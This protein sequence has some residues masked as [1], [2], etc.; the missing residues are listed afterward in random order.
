MITHSLRKIVLAVFVFAAIPLSAQIYRADQILAKH[1]KAMGGESLL[2]KLKS[3]K[4]E[5]SVEA[6]GLKGSSTLYAHTPDMTRKEIKL[7]VLNQ[8]SCFNG[9]DQWDI[10]ANGALSIGGEEARKSAYTEALIDC[11]GY[12]FPDSTIKIRYLSREG[13][14][15]RSFV[16]IEVLPEMG[17]PVKLW[18]DE[19][20][21]LIAKS[22]MTSGG[23][24]TTREYDDYEPAEGIMIPR[25]IR[26]S[27]PE[28]E[29]EYN[30]F[31]YTV[32]VNGYMDE[33]LFV[34]TEPAPVDYVIRGGDQSAPIPFEFSNAHI[35]LKGKINGDGPYDF[36]L[37]SGAEVSLVDATTARSLWLAPAGELKAEG[38]G[39]Y[40]GMPLVKVDSI[41]LPGVE[42]YGQVDVSMKPAELS[43]KYPGRPV[44]MVLGYD[45]LSRFAT[46]IRFSDST[47]T[48]HDHEKFAAPA[49]YSFATCSF[50]SHVPLVSAYA[51]GFPGRFILNTGSVTSIDL[52][53]PFIK[54]NNLAKGRRLVPS[55]LHG[56]SG[57]VKMFAARMK[58]FSIGPFVIEN[59][60][61]GFAQDARAGV[62]SS[63][64]VDG[65]VGMEVLRR[66][67]FIFDYDG[68]RVA[69]R[70]NKALESEFKAGKSG[71]IL[72]VA[73][74]GRIVVSGVIPG[75]PGQEAGVMPGEEIREVG[76][77]FAK[78]LGLAE[79]REILAGED[80]KE[81]TLTLAKGAETRGLSIKLRT[82]Y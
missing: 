35:Y 67:D 47:V 77:V 38:T 54:K 28:L 51:E 2:Y 32:E 57:S 1:I 25:S 66:F 24:T 50:D 13:E 37:D 80:G 22:E 8:V 30:Y 53:E 68:A 78:N 27:V 61:V 7:G 33:R 49:G 36:I 71:L 58:I 42:L 63:T 11:F 55:E 65:I 34:L 79:I 76:G 19:Q 16:V 15:G 56:S 31:I 81:I 62:L 14:A 3:I 64:D 73:D 59:P 48:I 26:E 18:L 23:F 82:Y 72:D 21:W 17:Y 20:T 40:A 74:E 70:Q 46:E 44:A 5:A 43:I 9:K 41:S 69:M 4:R 12:M 6:D 75:S 29:Q 39:E 45:F 60:V 52:S 10:D